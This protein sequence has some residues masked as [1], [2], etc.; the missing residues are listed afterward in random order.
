VTVF[1]DATAVVA[2]HI[3]TPARPPAQA[4]L[5]K[6]DGAVCV[7]ALSL[8]EALAVVDRLT[9][10]ASL[11]LELEDALRA[12]WDRYAVV[13][14]DQRC[15]DRAADLLREQ[16]LRLVDAVQLAAAERLPRPVRYV[17]FDPVQ[18]PTALGLGFDVVS[19]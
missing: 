12:Q 4:A 5:A 7:S 13:P 3:D 15:L 9:D 14:V 17:T 18:I 10:D 11:R 19:R 1:F 2:L 6:A 16:P 8:T